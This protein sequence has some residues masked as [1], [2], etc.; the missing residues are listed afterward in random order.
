MYRFCIN[1]GELCEHVQEKL[2][3]QDSG[4]VSAIWRT[5]AENDQSLFLLDDAQQ[6]L[7]NMAVPRFIAE[8]VTSLAEV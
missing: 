2:I 7:L 1:K 5:Q 4:D 3:R 8:K 6:L